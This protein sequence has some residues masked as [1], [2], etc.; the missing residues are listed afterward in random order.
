MN[1]DFQSCHQTQVPVFYPTFD[2]FKDFGKYILHIESQGAHKIGL[3]KIIPPVEWI[4]RKNGYDDLDDTTQIKIKTPISQ[5][6]EGKEGLYA[7]YNIQH[8]SMKIMEFE[9]LAKSSKYTTPPHKDFEE[10][11]RKYWKNLTFIPAIYGAD[12]SGTLTDSDQPYWNINK[13]GTILGIL[14]LPI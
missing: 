13:L 7:Q 8:K 12:I 10:L 5:S 9:N 11:E 14:I 6:V 3:A 2:E 1:Y 4:P